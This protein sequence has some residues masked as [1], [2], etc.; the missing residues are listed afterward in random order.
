MMKKRFLVLIS[1]YNGAQ[2]I[3][4]QVESLL[5]QEG[6]VANI[7]VRDDGSTDGVQKILQEYSDKGCLKWIQGSNVG[8]T[9]SFM[10]LVYMA[11]T[12][13]DYY[14]FCDQDDV[15]MPDKM[16]VAAKNL[17][18]FSKDKPS[19]YYSSQRLVDSNLNFISDHILDTR[20]SKETC[21]VFGNIAGCT[22][23]FNQKLL[24]KLQSYKC[25]QIWIH[26]GWTYKVCVALGGNIFVD[27]EPHILYRQHGNNEVGMTNSFKSV[28]KR[29]K[30]NLNEAHVLK[31][32]KLILDGFGDDVCPEFKNFADKIMA[33]NT[34]VVNWL[35]VMFMK[36]IQFY[37]VGLQLNYILKVLMKKL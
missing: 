12:D 31:E 36:E 20:R 24:I 7:M 22:A 17:H 15:W 33:Y 5:H 3:R 16:L 26:D 11:P 35:N 27:Q 8:A 4:E 1:T 28:R 13:Y 6:V 10:E 18:N 23:V 19:L 34:S 37:N 25:D 21:F 2:Y 29:V 32:T 30:K 9:K 14:A